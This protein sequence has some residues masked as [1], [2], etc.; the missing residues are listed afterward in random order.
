MGFRDLLHDREPE[1]RPRKPARIRSA[2]EAVEDVREILFR[3]SRPVVS[4]RDL[5]AADSDLDLAARRA[6]LRRVVEEVR[7]RA[8][9]RRGGAVDH[10]LLEVGRV[11]DIRA[12]PPRPLDRVG[13]DQV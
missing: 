9:D 3:D 12:V 4:D 6:P 13:G 5:F 8:L 2:V 7:D 10:R 11:G 1:P